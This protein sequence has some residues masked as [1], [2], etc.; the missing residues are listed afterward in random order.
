M[1]NEDLTAMKLRRVREMMTSAA[2]HLLP[3]RAKSGIWSQSADPSTQGTTGKIHF[4]VL[5][6]R[7]WLA[8]VPAACRVSKELVSA[9]VTILNS[10][11]DM[12]MVFSCSFDTE[13]GSCWHCYS[14]RHRDDEF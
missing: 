12:D 10:A 1:T 14:A 5:Y 7:W 11:T 3:I 8:E 4:V 2:L 13:M 6:G 9:G